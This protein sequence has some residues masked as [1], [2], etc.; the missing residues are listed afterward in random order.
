MPVNPLLQL[1]TP[2]LEE[3]LQEIFSA[4]TAIA[5]DPTQETVIAQGEGLVK[6]AIDPAQL[7]G[8]TIGAAAQELANFVSG[9]QAHLQTATAAPSAATAAPV[10]A[11]VNPANAD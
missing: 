4:A 8:I 2:A 3:V 9:L 11:D 1:F 5:A 7:E 6:D 10:T